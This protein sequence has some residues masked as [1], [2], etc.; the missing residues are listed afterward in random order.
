M[1][2]PNQN[3]RHPNTQNELQLLQN[4]KC[5]TSTSNRRLPSLDKKRK[6]PS[7]VIAYSYRLK[8]NGT[9]M[10]ELHRCHWKV[11]S[12]WYC[13]L[14]ECIWDGIAWRA[15]GMLIQRSKS[16][17]GKWKCKEFFVCEREEKSWNIEPN[18]TNS[19]LKTLNKKCNK[20]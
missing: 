15:I 2:F 16:E 12:K 6:L 7:F 11:E 3:P 14:F 1:T 13:F 10:S 5:L 20:K 19:S 18:E 8:L 4:P 9:T 17:N